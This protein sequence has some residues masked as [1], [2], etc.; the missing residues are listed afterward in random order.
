V[1]IQWVPPKQPQSRVGRA[2]PILSGSALKSAPFPADPGLL[3]RQ[4]W[5]YRWLQRVTVRMVE[6]ALGYYN[7]TRTDERISRMSK[8]GGMVCSDS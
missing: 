7:I 3:P 4:P 1:D 6:A 2:T 8:H 5:T